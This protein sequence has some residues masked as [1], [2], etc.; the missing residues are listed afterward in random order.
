MQAQHIQMAALG[1]VLIATLTTHAHA[2]NHT[3]FD[4]RTDRLGGLTATDLLLLEP[5]LQHGPATLVEFANSDADQLP[6][7]HVA[8]LID[9]PAE[10][11]AAVVGAPQN[12]PRFVRTLD[13][14]DVVSTYQDTSVYDWSWNL[15]ML[16]LKGRNNLS[17]FDPPAGREDE[18]YRFT[19]DSTSGDFG[20]GRMLFRIHPRPDHKS[21]LVLSVRL[22]LRASNFVVRQMAAA[23]RSVNRSANMSLA[24][25]LMFSVRKEAQRLAGHANGS[26]PTAQASAAA[27]SPMD[28]RALTP[29]LSR[30]DVIWFDM[31]GDALTDMHVVGRIERDRETVQHIMLDAEAFGSALMPGSDATVVSR[32]GAETTFDWDIAL[33]LI[34]L[35]GRMKMTAETEGVHIAA[36]DGALHG[37]TWR[38]LAQPLGKHA[39]LVTGFARF[40]IRDTNWLLRQLVDADPYLGHGMAAASEVMLVR[41]LRSR[42]SEKP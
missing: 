6:G 11:V 24:Y 17:R 22:D 9:A 30:G 7:I 10:T 12:Y 5:A 36:T 1:C 23:A 20:H 2:E 16:Q 35:S 4:A 8:A 33:P 27:A 38:F 18:G 37:G 29:L 3:A 19:V 31:A 15:G 42:A 39:T 34:G 32:I 21:L 14:V 26:T 41:A 28:P 13:R 40:D 25:A